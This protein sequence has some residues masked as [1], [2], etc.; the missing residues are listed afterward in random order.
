MNF[1]N[2]ISTASTSKAIHHLIIIMINELKKIG[3]SDKE[4][5]VY[6]AGL[7]LGKASVQDI[8][9]KAGVN[10]TTVYVMVGSLENRGLMKTMKVGKRTFFVSENPDTFLDVLKKSKKEIEEKEMEIKE[11]LPELKSLYN[12]APG[13][14]KIRLYEGADIYKK[15]LDD[16]FESGAKEIL[17]IIDADAARSFVSEEESKTH[18][19][20]R[21]EKGIKLK[22]LYTRKEGPYKNRLNLN[23]ERF[24]EKDKFPVKGEIFIYG[25][26][27][28]MSSV[29]QTNI[30][31]IIES[32][33][34]SDTTRTLF[35][36]AWENTEG[37]GQKKIA[38]RSDDDD[39]LEEGE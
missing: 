7:E 35:N 29:G 36:L 24:I 8:A 20:K 32:K 25:D 19:Q 28:G 33:E 10:R 23:D 16:L 37:G 14:P 12:V 21:I 34:I 2:S 17:E 27:V 1:I 13:K 38:D 6:L 31:V 22:A 39:E 11:I 18:Y 4:A 5:K 3:L 26:R 9:K 15:V 30:G